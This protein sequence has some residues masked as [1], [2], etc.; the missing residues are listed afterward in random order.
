MTAAWPL[1]DGV[2]NVET[3]CGPR[4]WP[5]LSRKPRVRDHVRR[6]VEA[7][8]GHGGPDLALHARPQRSAT[9]HPGRAPL[10]PTAQLGWHH[11]RFQVRDRK[12]QGGQ[13]SPQ[14]VAAVGAG[15]WWE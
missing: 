6:G 5:W 15:L 3:V 10:L 9:E 11:P 1:P 7:D 13:A 4:V 12:A 14:K 2:F 8:A